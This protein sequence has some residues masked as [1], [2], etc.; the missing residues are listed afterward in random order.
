MAEIRK[1][2]VTD[3]IEK[4]YA[5]TDFDIQNSLEKRHEFRKQFILNDKCL[6][7]D[8]KSYAIKLLIKDFDDHKI[9][10]NEGTKRICENCYNKCLAT[11]YCEYCVR[12]Y[13]KEDFSNWTSGND[14]IDNLIRKCQ[15]ETISPEK[16]VE[17]I[18]YDNFQNVK[19]VN[20]SGCSEFYTADW[21]DGCYDE[22]DSKE[23]KLKRLGDQ[24]VILKKLENVKNAKKSWFEEG[25]TNLT[26][27][28]K[29]NDI[30]QCYGF[31]KDPTDGNYMLVM[32]KMDMNLRSYLIKNHNKLTWK[33]RIQ[34][35]HG[36]INAL[37]RIHD[38]KA[39]HKNLHSGN[40]LFSQISQK[41]RISDLGF[42][43]PADKPLNSIYGK[44]PYI[45]P[46]VIAGKETTFASNIYSI[47]ILMWEI[48]SGIQ[49]F[50]NYENNLDLAT[51][52][53][54]GMRPKIVQG[55]PLEYE[56]LMEQCWDSDPTKRPDIYILEDKL[57]AMRSD[58]NYQIDIANF[59][60][61]PLNTNFGIYPGLIQFLIRNST[62]KIYNFKDLP[63]PKNATEEERE[64][65]HSI[66]NNLSILND[67]NSGLKGKSKR[68]NLNDSDEENDINS[69]KLKVNHD[70][71]GFQHVRR[72]S[73]DI[74]D[75]SDTSDDDDDEVFIRSN[76][77]QEVL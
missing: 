39:I 28:N 31:T 11:L 5:S 25:K 30:V 27:S 24:E 10:S 52:I 17:W 40:I 37:Y 53:I 43:E 35:A 21:I 42:C 72:S 66:Q 60:N 76:I 58:Q 1:K 56:K 34:I 54:N 2:L 15:I 64:V 49:P 22:W 12:D 41:F 18:P 61:L 19:Y 36:I 45:A 6:T 46:E 23:M 77:R 57:D 16:I 62:S 68:I 65:F 32:V 73:D 29:W 50:I 33:E 8:E 47:G 69:K 67:N 51:N 26:I 71:V 3:A 4:A 74:D 38:E 44:L 59:N 75:I 9:L 48:S 7:E 20:K 14:D 13:L 63:E 55:T 70:E